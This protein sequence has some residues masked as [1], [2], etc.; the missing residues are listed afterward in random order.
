MIG[1]VA[2]AMGWLAFTGRASIAQADELRGAFS[3]SDIKILGLGGAGL[4]ALG[5]LVEAGLPVA[6]LIAMDTDSPALAAS[7]ASAQVQLGPQRLHRITTAG[8]EASSDEIRR[9]LRGA[10]L[11]IICVG[12]GGGTGSGAAPSVARLARESGATVVVFASLPFIFEGR[13]RQARAREALASIRMF[14][15]E[16]TTFENDRL[17]E[18]LP[19]ETSLVDALEFMEERIC[20]SV[21][22]RSASGSACG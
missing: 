14:A 13:R 2:A 6:N 20:R 10:S 22:Q 1:S 16:I 21:I 3:R 12:L 19:P 5:R 8:A 18:A 17:A 4:T 7:R 9:S 11:V 15:D